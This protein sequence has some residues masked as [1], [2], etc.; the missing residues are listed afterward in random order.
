MTQHVVCYYGSPEAKH[1]LF[2][3][4]VIT[5]LVIRYHNLFVRYLE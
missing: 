3:P 2:C 1:F 5:T 4:S